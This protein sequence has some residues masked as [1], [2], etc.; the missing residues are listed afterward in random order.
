MRLQPCRP[1]R[2]QHGDT[3]QADAEYPAVLHEHGAEREVGERR[4]HQRIGTQ[5]QRSEQEQQ[6]DE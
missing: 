1:Q 3:H 4:R 2:Q 5:P 6:G